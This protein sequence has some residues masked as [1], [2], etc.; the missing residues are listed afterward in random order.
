MGPEG[1]SGHRRADL[2]TEQQISNAATAD[3]KHRP[4]A[5][6]FFTA[7]TDD[8]CS[9]GDWQ[10]AAGTDYGVVQ[11]ERLDGG[12]S[13]FG[14]FGIFVQNASAFDRWHESAAEN[15]GAAMAL[16]GQNVRLA[17]AEHRG[18]VGVI[19]CVGCVVVGREEFECDP[20][21]CDSSLKHGTA[22]TAVSLPRRRFLRGC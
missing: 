3:L 9:T 16:E 18:M 20:I 22:T 7:K 4:F 11:F 14:A 2:G 12:F 6:A 19:V 17:D 5:A 10:S 8:C 13:A 15:C 21:H 1:Q